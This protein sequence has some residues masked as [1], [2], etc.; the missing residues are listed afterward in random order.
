MAG[1]EGS[2]LICSCP[3]V[4]R[5]GG[6]IWLSFP[7]FL[8]DML[9]CRSI[10]RG[11]GG[12]LGA[13]GVSYENQP[14]QEPRSRN[15]PAAFSLALIYDIPLDSHKR[16]VFSIA[17]TRTPLLSKNLTPRRNAS[18]EFFER[19]SVS[20]QRKCLLIFHYSTAHL[21]FQNH[22]YICIYIS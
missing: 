22:I 20:R 19:M 18:R 2:P 17:L 9:P 7:L 14:P 12:A 13:P 11:G 5:L 21:Y 1:R 15:I 6:Y 3:A 10:S 8:T 4:G 16:S